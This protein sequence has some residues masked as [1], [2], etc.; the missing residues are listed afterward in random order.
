ML[1]PIIFTANN[2]GGSS[3]P[4]GGDFPALQFIRNY[5]LDFGTVRESAKWM[6]LNARKQSGTL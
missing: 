3:K 6:I 2:S 1:I 4:I 5:V